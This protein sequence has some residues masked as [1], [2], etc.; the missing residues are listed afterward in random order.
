MSFT[1][2]GSRIERRITILE[3]VS[4]SDASIFM[5]AIR[6]MTVKIASDEWI[7]FTYRLRYAVLFE[8]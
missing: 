3:F 5:C 6:F 4:S 2:S 1:S 8:L 7:A